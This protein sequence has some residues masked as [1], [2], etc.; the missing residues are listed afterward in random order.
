MLGALAW[1]LAAELSRKF[2]F[3]GLEMSLV[4]P[5]DGIALGLVLAYGRG[6][7][8]AI[9]GA[10]ILWHMQRGIGL[11]ESVIG[12]GALMLAM[13]AVWWLR[14]LD[15]RGPQPANPVTAAIRFHLL[16]LLPATCILVGLGSWQYL[17]A[18]VPGKQSWH[19]IVLVMGVSELFG[20][21][22][23]A[24][25]TKLLVDALDRPR[26]PPNLSV[27]WWQLWW[28]VSLG[29]LLSIGSI[30]D[31]SQFNGINASVRY[32]VF[33]LVAWAAFAGRPLFVHMATALAA[34][35]LLGLTPAHLPDSDRAFLIL[36]Q[37]VLVICLAGLGFFASAAMEHRRAMED[38]LRELA[39]IDTLTGML[40]ERGL[41]QYL[42]KPGVHHLLIGIAICNLE[43][44]EDLIGMPRARQVEEDIA[45]LLRDQVPQATRFARVRDG[46]FV[47][48]L[49][50]QMSGE[51]FTSHLQQVLSGRRYV[52]GEQGVRIRVAMSAL[53]TQAGTVRRE[54]TLA[55]LVLAC[56]IAGD[57]DGLGLI[58]VNEAP[59]VLIRERQRQLSRVEALREA[60]RHPASSDADGTGLWLACQ[61]IRA[62]QDGQHDDL[63]VEVLLRWSLASGVAVA[64]SEFLPL[65]ER[66]GLMP[67]VDRWVIAQVVRALAN[68]GA[69]SIGLEKI[70]INL[71]GASMSDAQLPGYIADAIQS[72][73]LEAKRFCFEITES[74][75]ITE[76][77]QAISLLSDV[78]KLGAQTSLDDFGT[79]LA[80]FDHLKSLPLD[81]VKIDGSFIRNILTSRVDQRIVISTCEVARA[82]GLKTV[83]EF[84]E[85]P[86]QRSLLAA[87]GVDFVQGY[88]ISPPMPFSAYLA[89]QHISPDLAA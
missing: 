24:R 28:L 81:F 69:A 11:S 5:P 76:R 83:A 70:S 80:T 42:E 40:N 67:L 22:L 39:R 54:E 72:S 3:G 2:S 14:Q 47:I 6:M 73:G 60:L 17:L 46:F 20:I 8:P 85:T 75:N 59:E 53:D 9:G 56:R 43:P 41:T 27:G 48:A 4:W 36:D 88:G 49:P 44:I 68:Q 35:A 64:P 33:P 31:Y 12:A 71:S 23:F 34:L 78:R 29:I 86:A 30:A 19:Q 65:A 79:G 82:M 66:H 50:P 18:N 16:T 89:L 55:A 25:L 84:V 61:P 58:A 74:S 63:G 13:Y 15:L 45:H 77:S 10:V 1:I 51:E 62:A 32:A 87:Y 37:A 38:S 7:I 57:S 21:L 26:K 52:L